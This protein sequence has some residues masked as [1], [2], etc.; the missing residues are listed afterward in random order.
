MILART[1]K[2]KGLRLTEGKY[3]WHSKVA[4][5]AEL[6]TVAEELAIEEVPA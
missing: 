4:S 5:A 6:R 3:E 2:G 1:V